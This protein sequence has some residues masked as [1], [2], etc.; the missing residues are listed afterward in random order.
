MEVLVIGKSL[1]NLLFD[2]FHLETKNKK[3]RSSVS[4]IELCQNLAKLGYHVFSID[5]RG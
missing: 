2:S 3:L 4:R 5:V 1:L